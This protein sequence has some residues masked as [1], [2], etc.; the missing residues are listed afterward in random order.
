MRGIFLSK[1]ETKIDDKII[2]KLSH[3]NFISQLMNS[4]DYYINHQLIEFII[5]I[6]INLYLNTKSYHKYGL[7]KSSVKNYKE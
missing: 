3:E 6:I 2:R 7:P 1:I 4:H 5:I